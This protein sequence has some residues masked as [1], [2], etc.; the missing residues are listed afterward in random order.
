MASLAL[1]SDA[2]DGGLT[3]RFAPVRDADPDEVGARTGHMI[4]RGEAVTTVA[5]T[6]E[7]RRH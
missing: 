2:Q 7:A 4:D 1:D 6:G 5:N 3:S